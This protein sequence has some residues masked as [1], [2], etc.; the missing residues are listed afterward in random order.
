MEIKLIAHRNYK[1]NPLHIQIL[2]YAT[3][4]GNP[5]I[6]SLTAKIVVCPKFFSFFDKSKSISRYTI[7]N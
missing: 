6:L 3:H 1:K 2:E 5:K 7:L 4:N